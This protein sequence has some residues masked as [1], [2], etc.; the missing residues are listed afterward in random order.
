MK[1][2]EREVNDSEFEDLHDLMSVVVCCVQTEKSNIGGK[3]E[4]L[5]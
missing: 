3:F 1:I 5:K 4:D 2:L